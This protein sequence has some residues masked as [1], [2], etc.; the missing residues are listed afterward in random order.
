MAVSMTFSP[1]HVLQSPTDGRQPRLSSPESANSLSACKGTT[2]IFPQVTSRR[3]QHD[4]GLSQ[5][6]VINTSWA[7]CRGCPRERTWVLLAP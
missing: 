1:S 2:C 4:L 7:L 3:G 5:H 6:P